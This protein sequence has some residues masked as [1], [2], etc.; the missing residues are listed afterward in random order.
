M[1][2]DLKKKT[3]GTEMFLFFSVFVALNDCP[4]PDYT[5]L[6]SEKLRLEFKL[7]FKRHNEITIIILGH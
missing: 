1:H 7:S 3:I 2:E 6:T 4:S 5:I